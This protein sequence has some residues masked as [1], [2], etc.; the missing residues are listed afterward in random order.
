MLRET[1]H[2]EH[3]DSRRRTS[4]RRVGADTTY[5][6]TRRKLLI[7][8][9]AIALA[10]PIDGFAQQ[11][12]KTM[13]RIAFLDPG[14][15]DSGLYGPFLA[16]MKEL[17]YIEGKNI[18]IQTRFA[19]GDLER[20]PAL[21]KELADLK[22][23]LILAQSTP[24]VRAV[25]ATKTTAPIVMVAVGDPV[26]SGF[27]KSLGRPGGNVTG[28]SILTSDVSPKLLEM[29]KTAIPR[30]SRV[31]VLVNSA[32][33]NSTVSLKNIEVA[34]GSMDL[35]VLPTRVSAVGE[36]DAALAAIAK[37]RPDALLIPGD[38]LFRLNARK[39]A[40]LALRYKLPLAATNREIVEAGG[41]FSYGASIADS[42][43]RAAA[44]VDKILKG[45]KPAE[46]PVEQSSKFDLVING[47]TAAALGIKIPPSLRITAEKVIE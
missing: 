38:P 7:A 27:V 9:G 32:N 12:V 39:I 22:P 46:L 34:A 23:D 3:A 42:Y 47:K 4:H 25:V 29:L 36:I 5:R 30:L 33:A 26:G 18:A 44:Y 45:A 21:A 43:R 20:L 16:G 31:A 1:G 41:L 2:M 11:S 14:A 10:A 28:M 8:L 37:Q 15:R 24:G 40:A 19:N 17:G 35:K 13:P 6:S